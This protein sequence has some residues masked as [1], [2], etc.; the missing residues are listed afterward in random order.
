MADK[1]RQAYHQ[2]YIAR[3]RYSNALPPPPCPP[4]LLDI[5]NTGLSSGRYT[6][7]GFATRLVREQ[8]LNIEADAELGMPIDLVG[9]PGV[10]DGNES[11]RDDMRSMSISA[12]LRLAIQA[13]DT[14]PML[15]PADRA[16]MRAPN[17]LGKAAAGASGA[18]FLRRTEYTTSFFAGSSKF[19]SSNS[20]N[21]IR[22]K[23]KRQ[24]TGN[25]SQNDP[26]NIAR[27]ILKGF[28]LAYPA[29]AYNGPDTADQ[30]RGAEISIE[31]KAAW[32]NPKHPS[33][34]SLQLLDSYPLIPDW[35]ALPDTGSYLMY[36]FMAPPT[37][38]TSGQYDE[39]LDVALLRPAGQSIDD[40]DRY[41]AEVE[42]A[43]E[44]PTLP[45]P[46]PRYHYEF[47]LPPDKEK[48]PGI[49]RNF[50]TYDADNED[51]IPFDR[52][53]DD[54]GNPRKFFTFKN[55]RT[56]ETV[57]QQSDS[58]NTF[59][60]VVALALHDPESHGAAPLRSSKL[61][62]AAYFYPIVSK[63]SLRPKRP[64]KT[65]M[66]GGDQQRV[67]IIE[68]ATRDPNAGEVDRREA[69]RKQYDITEV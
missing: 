13:G 65:E 67:D 28:N 53:Q 30:L 68:T 9:I 11:G 51:E 40:E 60:D 55:I 61:Q 29:D 43:K 38:E 50:T 66:A 27:H 39:R 12:Y 69:F 3:I 1:P 35:D 23:T 64:G 41:I 48:V 10:F 17:A 47:Y 4:K 25:V 21:T 19:E 59:N 44:D 18:S 63:R 42:A 37:K 58:K 36:K 34:P 26:T 20:S 62:K 52:G 33:N 2:D 22:M 49:K 14:K 32:K 54:D 8:P 57:A 16:L 56:Y 31:E 24:R 46:L 45:E 5:P 6:S 7:A 15:H